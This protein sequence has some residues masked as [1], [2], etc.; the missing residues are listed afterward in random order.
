VC[1]V[2]PEELHL[3]NTLPPLAPLF[4]FSFLFFYPI[5]LWCFLSPRRVHFI[6]PPPPPWRLYISIYLSVSVY[7]C[8]R[9]SS[10]ACSGC[11]L[12]WFGSPL[13]TRRTADICLYVPIYL[14]RFTSICIYLSICLYMSIYLYV[15]LSL[16]VS[17]FAHRWRP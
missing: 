15:Y 12:F 8:V 10:S 4:L 16:C 11:N 5:L 6:N 3:I 7:L 1:S 9:S 17:N 13:A 2:S 14:Y